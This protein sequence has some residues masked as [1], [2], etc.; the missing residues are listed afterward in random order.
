MREPVKI[1]RNDTKGKFIDTLTLDGL[2]VNLTGCTIKFLLRRRG[3]STGS[4]E[5]MI[6][7]AAIAGDPQLGQV[8]YQPVAD[9]VEVEG[10]YDHEWQVTFADGKI[11]TVPNQTFNTVEILRDLGQ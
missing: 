5:T 8:E 3:R 1:K 6:R 9:D 11:L 7:D 4:P 10:I 2:P